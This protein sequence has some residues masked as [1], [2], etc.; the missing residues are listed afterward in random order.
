MTESVIANLISAVLGAVLLGAW[1]LAA[2]P[3]YQKVTYQGPHLEGTWVFSNTDNGSA[4]DQIVEV[5]QYG[6]H[7]KG[8]HT[9]N[10]WRD[11]SSAN[12]KIPFAGQVFGNKVL[13]YGV[14]SASGTI[15]S[16][17]LEILDSATR[18]RGY[19]LTIEPATGKICTHRREWARK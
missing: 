9:V 12:V 6:R 15:G 5:R 2:V 18:V 1:R 3:W 11:G 8:T 7:I 19:V 4:H 14:D 13:L 17:L 10:R 16:Q